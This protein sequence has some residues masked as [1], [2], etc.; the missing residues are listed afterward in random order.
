MA[1]AERRLRRAL[2]TAL[3]AFIA[4]FAVG[5][6][7]GPRNLFL[8]PLG[9]IAAS[10]VLVLVTLRSAALPTPARRRAGW[11]AIVGLV[12]CAGVMYGVVGIWGFYE[13]VD[14]VYVPL[15]F[16]S[17]LLFVALATKA[18]GALT[19]EVP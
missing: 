12:F 18:R 15:V 7:P 13:V 2:G 6:L 4:V 14:L 17:G 8:V 11:A 1:R 3:L 19:R 5:A 16:V 9:L 10:C